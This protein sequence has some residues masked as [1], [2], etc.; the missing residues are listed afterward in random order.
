MSFRDYFIHHNDPHHIE[1]MYHAF[2][3]RM[4]HEAET[5]TDWDLFEEA[6]KAVDN[7]IAEEA[8]DHY[9]RYTRTEH[10]REQWAIKNGYVFKPKEYNPQE[11]YR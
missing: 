3:E 11:K 8:E 4:Y 10:Y 6:Q 5:G 9:Y 2:K 1:A 7:L